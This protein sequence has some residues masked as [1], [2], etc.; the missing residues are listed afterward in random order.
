[1]NTLYVMVYPSGNFGASWSGCGDLSPTAHIGS[2]YFL[3]GEDDLRRAK[4]YFSKELS[5]GVVIKPITFT[6]GETV[7]PSSNG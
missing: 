1:M 4:D 7:F 3:Y 2:A 6:L 5:E